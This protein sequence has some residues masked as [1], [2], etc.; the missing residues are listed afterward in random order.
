[1]V[2]L[3]EV[4]EELVAYSAARTKPIA[5]LEA[6]VRRHRRHRRLAASSGVALAAAVVAVV[7]LLALPGDRRQRVT[8]TGSTPTAPTVSPTPPGYHRVNYGNA[9]IAAPESWDLLRAGEVQCPAPAEVVLLGNAEQGK[10]GPESPGP[11]SSFVRLQPLAASLP[12]GQPVAINGHS[13]IKVSES[14]GSE[15]YLFPDLGVELT[16]G[17]EDA[18]SITETVGWSAT[19][20]VS[21]PAGP[22]QIP[23][24]WRKLQFEGVDFRVP[25]DWPVVELGTTIPTPGVCA[26]PEF[27]RPVVDE[28]PGG[29]QTCN[30]FG[31]Y[32]PVAETDGIWLRTYNP[33]P[34]SGPLGPDSRFPPSGSQ[35]LHPGPRLG[36]A[37]P[38][39][40]QRSAG[41]RTR[42][43]GG[44][45]RQGSR[46]HRAGVQSDNGPRSPSFHHRDV[47]PPKEHAANR[48]N[49][50][51]HENAAG[52]HHRRTTTGRA[53]RNG[54]QSRP[55]GRW[56]QLP[57]QRH[58]QCHCPR[59]RRNQ[60]SPI[61]WL[62]CTN[63]IDHRPGS[64]NRPPKPPRT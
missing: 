24:D 20:L 56:A 55:R 28:G 18:A 5:N 49:T 32:A 22:V 64:V 15:T 52:H 23:Q 53:D 25:P 35:V 29:P 48:H 43:S 44:Q 61:S 8:V 33:A 6:R 16:V 27:P 63:G 17:G 13:G 36:R 3:T 26:N 60:P 31:P 59:W 1:M 34:A 50:H 9:S 7:A 40:Q 30:G 2:D 38:Y 58:R 62:G 4:A 41:G 11:L 19:Y 42:R 47:V 37:P 46:R 51:D 57:G 21:H 54:R 45:R 14:A 10:C 39:G 12:S